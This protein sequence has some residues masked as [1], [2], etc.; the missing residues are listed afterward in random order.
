MLVVAF[1]FPG[2]LLTLFSYLFHHRLVTLSFAPFLVVHANPQY[3]LITGN[4]P[5]DV[6]GKP[7]HEVIQ[8]PACKATTAKTHSLASLNNQVTDFVAPVASRGE[9]TKKCRVHVSVVGTDTAAVKENRSLVT[10]F[11]VSLTEACHDDTQDLLSE[12]AAT[13]TTTVLEDSDAVNAM[14]TNLLRV[15]PLPLLETSNAVPQQVHNIRLH[16]GVMG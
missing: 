6:L 3:S 11:M 9:G 8:D 10:H 14:A 7:L 12:E 15:V 13:D 5:A 1:L 4:A 2:P 16:C